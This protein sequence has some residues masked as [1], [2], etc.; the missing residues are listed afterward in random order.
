M[1]GSAIHGQEIAER[2]TATGHQVHEAPD[3]FARWVDSGDPRHLRDIEHSPP[4]PLPLK[5][6]TPGR[7]GP[8][9]ASKTNESSLEDSRNV[10]L[11]HA[12][13]NTECR[14]GA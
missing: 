8:G 4:R 3:A 12:A 2:M 6:A 13:V 11:R 9:V 5:R 7:T 14:R 1:G 10:A